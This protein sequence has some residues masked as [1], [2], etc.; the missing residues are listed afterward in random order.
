MSPWHCTETT[1]RPVS[2]FV[3][4]CLRATESAFYFYFFCSLSPVHWLRHF[5]PRHLPAL[6]PSEHIHRELDSCF[7]PYREN[8]CPP[9]VFAFTASPSP[10]SAVILL[11][12]DTLGRRGRGRGRWWVG[13]GEG[14]GG[15]GPHAA[16][17]H[18]PWH[19]WWCCPAE[20]GRQSVSVL[21]ASDGR[22]VKLHYP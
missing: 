5:V 10:Y 3:T 14:G 19:V 12:S 22:S 4:L 20:L 7:S 9:L 11:S 15:G 1:L 17:H 6:M 21:C 18:G 13:G 8:F 16:K 2:G